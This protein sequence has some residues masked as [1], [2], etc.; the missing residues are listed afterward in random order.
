[1]SVPGVFSES[2]KGCWSRPPA[3]D[4]VVLVA[5][6]CVTVAVSRQGCLA[7]GDSSL[8]CTTRTLIGPSRLLSFSR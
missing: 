1:M 2:D 3:V 4:V 8:S 7:G 6:T 5:C